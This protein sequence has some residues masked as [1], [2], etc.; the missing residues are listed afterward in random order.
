MTDAL[1]AEGKGGFLALNTYMGS[2]SLDPEVVENLKKNR[3]IGFSHGLEKFSRPC[4]PS[5]ELYP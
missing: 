5:S 3:Q 1:V 4:Y 2:S